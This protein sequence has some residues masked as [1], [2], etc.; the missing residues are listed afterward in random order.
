MAMA[1]DAVIVLVLLFV[2]AGALLPFN[3]GEAVEPGDWR[4]TAYLGAVCFAYFVLCWTRFGRTPGMR[5]WRLWIENTR[6]ERPNL[7]AATG[8]FVGAC[9]SLLACG[10]GVIWALLD[11]R[12][13]TW[14]SRWSS[15]RLV[16]KPPPGAT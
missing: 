4:M 12:G 3:G 2:A 8:R 15:T 16:H 14:H 10:G 5:A 13:L 1:Y 7:G 6:G 11:P 9:V